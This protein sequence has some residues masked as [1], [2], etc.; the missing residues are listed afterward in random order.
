M[1]ELL[2]PAGNLEK[3][4]IAFD[5]GADAVYLGGTAFG[6]RASAGN[7]TIDQIKEGIQY[8]HNKNGKVYVVLN[9]LAH[10]TDM[11]SL[12]P[13]LKQLDEI[14][15]DG[16][17]VAD[18]GIISWVLQYT[19]LPVHLS[20]QASATHIEAIRFWKNQGVSRIVLAREVSIK[21]AKQ[22]KEEVDVELEM[23]IHGSMCNSYSGKCVISNYTHLRDANRGGCVQSCR[24]K[25]DTVEENEALKSELYLLN[26]KDL[27]AVDYIPQMIDA[28]IESLKIEGRMKSNMY[29]ANT[30]ATYRYLIDYYIKHGSYDGI[31]VEEIHNQIQKISNR[32]FYTGFLHHEFRKQ[33][34][35]PEIIRYDTSEYF[36]STEYIGTVKDF[37]EG[38]SFVL[39]VAAP[40]S[41]GDR[42]EILLHDG[43]IVQ[44]DVDSIHNLLRHSIP[45]ANPNMLVVLPWIEGIEKN[46][47]IR[48]DKGGRS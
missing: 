41:I 24:F 47:V 18:P 16:L 38:N 11:D 48:R 36:S 46:T 3:L 28:G 2:A 6:L 27:Q 37:K 5:Y 15:P 45:K 22:I 9:I 31:N 33:P 34:S 42:L 32:T 21:E 29:L 20:T 12:L 39:D 43:T 26:S 23:F 44:H 8:A 1:T 7:F 40:F 25:Y 10:H 17:I 14:K 4:K 35:H 13:Y 30:V 19:H